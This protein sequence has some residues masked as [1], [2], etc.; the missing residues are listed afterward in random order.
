MHRH[1]R[2]P[3]LGHHSYL[4]PSHPRH[5]LHHRPLRHRQHHLLHHCCCPSRLQVCLPRSRRTPSSPPS[6]PFA[7]AASATA[8]P[9]GSSGITGRHDSLCS[10]DTTLV[11]A[12]TRIPA[13]GVPGNLVPF[14]A[15]LPRLGATPDPRSGFPKGLV[16]QLGPLWSTRCSVSRSQHWWRSHQC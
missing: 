5:P 3:R 12:N 8:Q 14:K 1:H 4:P 13:P 7:A 15:M 10:N 2:Q 6:L 11:L 9:P 16:I